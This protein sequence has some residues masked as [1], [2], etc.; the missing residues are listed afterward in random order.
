MGLATLARAGVISSLRHTMAKLERRLL[1][2]RR[3][4]QCLPALIGL[5]ALVGRGSR[6]MADDSVEPNEKQASRLAMMRKTATSIALTERPGEPSE[7]VAPLRPEPVLRYSDPPRHMEDASMWAW[8]DHGRPVAMLK[9]ELYPPHPPQRRWVLGLV[10]LSADRISVRYH[11]GQTWT[12]S[13]PGLELRELT[14]APVP[15]GTETLRM[16]QMKALARRF[17]ASED[18]GAARG[19]IELRLMPRPF[20]RYADAA[21]GLLDGALFGFATGTNPDI[22]LVIEAWKSESGSPGFQFQY[23]LARNGGGHFRV[24]L[25]GNEV[26]AQGLANPPVELETYMNRWIAEG[27]EPR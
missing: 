10:S 24:K 19:R 22:F 17:T 4:L 21:A 11:D 13:K 18:A 16:A 27:E 14:G 25:D 15:G 5:S 9:V 3:L 12:S 2:R 26:W 20:D 7:R 1:S 8:G 23:G 6:L